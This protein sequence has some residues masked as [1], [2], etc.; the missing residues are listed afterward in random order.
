MGMD[1]LIGVREGPLVDATGRK[2]RPARD[3]GFV[4]LRPSRGT[5]SKDRSRMSDLSSISSNVCRTCSTGTPSEISA[6]PSQP[7]QVEPK[8]PG[9]SA[10]SVELSER[11]RAIAALLN[12]DAVN[13]SRGADEIRQ[14]LVDRVRSEIENGTYESPEK[15]SAAAWNLSRR[16][17]IRQ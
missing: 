6:R 9:R 17:D 4:A 1:S 14:D 11:A 15:L 3:P 8:T 10:D 12:T 16:L 5:L 2:K 13:A 7:A